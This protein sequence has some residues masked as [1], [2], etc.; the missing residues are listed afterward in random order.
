MRILVIP[1]IHLK[2]WI[3]DRAEKILE[4]GEADRAVCLMDIADDY[5]QAYN[6]D[7]YIKTYDRAI[8]FAKKFP[9]TLWCYGNHDICYEINMRETG[10]S[11]IAEYTV[12]TKL[13]ELE[14]SLPDPD[15]LGFIHRVDN[16]LF[17]HGG[18]CSYFADDAIPEDIVK[19]VNK[20]V[21]YINH[22]IPKMMMWGDWTPLWYRPQIGYRYP[23]YKEDELLQVV[24]HTPVKYPMMVNGVLSCDTFSTSS[25]K[26][27]FGSQEFVIIDSETKEW[28]AVPSGKY[29]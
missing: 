3:F 11:K 18:F 10:Y 15:Q 26:T 21:H 7:Q 12:C 8:A 24:G 27:P 2:D 5:G 25:D 17:M 1:D 14:R 20:T 13:G 22:E 29:E 16:L 9:D 6:L 28:T 23:L 19:D 4:A